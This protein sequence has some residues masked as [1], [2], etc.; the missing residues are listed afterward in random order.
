M[1]PLGI[2]QQLN[3]KP[4]SNIVGGIFC[5]LMKKYNQPFSEIHKIPV[6]MLISILKNLEEENK[7]I[8]KAKA[9]G[10]RR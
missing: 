10:V 2:Q 9:G 1:R 7:Q 3:R 4:N 6:P 5:L 8:K